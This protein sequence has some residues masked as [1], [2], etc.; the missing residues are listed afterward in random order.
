MRQEETRN[1][2]INATIQVFARD[3]IDKATTKNLAA[4][5]GLNEVYIH[6]NEAYN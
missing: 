4:E 3:G 5:A 1:T 6:K 2:L